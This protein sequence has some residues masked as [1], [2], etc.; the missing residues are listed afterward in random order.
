MAEAIKMSEAVGKVTRVSKTVAVD[1]LGRKIATNS[2]VVNLGAG[3]GKGGGKPRI[4][5]TAD[6][7]RECFINYLDIVKE[8]GFKELPTKGNFANFAGIDKKTIY[9]TSNEYFPETKK[10]WQVAL[11]DCLAEGSAV[12]AYDKTITIFCLKN[13]CDWADKREE[14]VEQKTVTL[15][16]KEEAKKALEDYANSKKA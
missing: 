13:W 8:N 14:K 16:T 10:D 6:E 12:G 5:N 11:A 15:A 3:M 9:N 1:E 2:K 4:F 7:Y